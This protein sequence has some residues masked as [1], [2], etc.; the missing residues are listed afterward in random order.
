MFLGMVTK[1]TKPKKPLKLAKSLKVAKPLKSSQL[2]KKPAHTSSGKMMTV[3]QFRPF[4][5]S[6]IKDIDTQNVTE[7]TMH[8]ADD[9]K[10]QWRPTKIIKNMY[11]RNPTFKEMKDFLLSKPAT[12]ILKHRTS[13]G[14]YVCVDY[15]SDLH[16]LAQK[17]GINA[18]LVDILYTHGD[19]HMMVAFNTTDKGMIF[20]DF[21]MF[22]NYD[23]D[24]FLG[25]DA[26][27]K[28]DAFFKVVA[29][30]HYATQSG[31]KRNIGSVSITW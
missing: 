30:P 28:K 16:N 5:E 24:G 4:S 22:G 1:I 7:L 23:M 6:K 26:K 12:D 10:A 27:K 9:K 21:S 29:R 14:K 17:S 25:K 31:N 20:V 13:E 11:A 18:G 8:L 3:S 19:G 2:N 15:S